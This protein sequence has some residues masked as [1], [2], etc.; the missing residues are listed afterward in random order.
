MSHMKHEETQNQ[1]RE[2]WET[3]T[4]LA[5]DDEQNKGTIPMPM[6]ARR[7]STMSSSIPVKIPQNPMA[8]QQRQQMSELQFDKFPS[9]HSFLCWKIRF[10][11]QVTTCSQRSGNCQFI[12]RIKI[13]AISCWKKFS[14]L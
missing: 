12:R 5:R 13:L 9:P 10:K 14:K 2:Q 8:G 7:A 3:G 4:S 6:F 1:F 11:N